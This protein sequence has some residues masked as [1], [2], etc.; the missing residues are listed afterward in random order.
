MANDLFAGLI[1]GVHA[2]AHPYGCS[3]L[4][5]D[6][7]NTQK[8]LA[9]LIRH[10]NAGGVLVLGLGC[11]NNR[12]ETLLGMAGGVERERV[13]YFSSQMAVGAVEDGGDAVEEL[14]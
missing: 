1:D 14:V 2:F 10:P 9:S 7:T 8:I 5:D 3:Q 13:R 12:L 6:L 11:E 4:G